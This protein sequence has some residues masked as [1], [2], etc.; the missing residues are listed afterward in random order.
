MWRGIESGGERAAPASV[1]VRR[2]GVSISGVCRQ[3]TQLG[4]IRE[5]SLTIHA[6]GVGPLY[7][8]YARQQ[9]R[10]RMLHRNAR[11]HGLRRCYPGYEH[12]VRGVL[13]PRQVD[14]FGGSVGGVAPVDSA[15]CAKGT[16]AAATPALP[17]PLK[18]SRREI[19]AAAGSVFSG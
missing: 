12:R 8:M 6:V 3:T 10:T 14:L 9:S 4:V 16:A 19:A 7:G 18:N 2:D 11:V 13:T 15:E 17:A 1:I 5:N